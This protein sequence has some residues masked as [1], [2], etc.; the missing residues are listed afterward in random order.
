ME[1]ALPSSEVVRS[2][3]L[4]AE[5]VGEWMSLLVGSPHFLLFFMGELMYGTRRRENGMDLVFAN[6]MA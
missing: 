6:A 5:W 1:R 2:V 3:L 4:G